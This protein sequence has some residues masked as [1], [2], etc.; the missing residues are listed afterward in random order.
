MTL[1]CRRIWRRILVR[2]RSCVPGRRTLSGSMTLSAVP[3]RN[4]PSLSLAERLEKRLRLS[5]K[6]VDHHRFALVHAAAAVVVGAIALLK[7]LVTVTVG[8][9]L[10]K[11]SKLALVEI[12]D[13]EVSRQTLADLEAR[14][15]TLWPAQTALSLPT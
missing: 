14:A 8:A 7:K 13:L 5:Q 4:A 9:L 2:W 10:N 6:R 3:R 12:E 1:A 11:L 15:A